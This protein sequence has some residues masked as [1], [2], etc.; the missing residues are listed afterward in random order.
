MAAAKDS[1]GLELQQAAKGILALMV[2]ERDERLNG[3]EVRRTEVILAEAG[4]SLGEIAGITG[5]KYETVKTIVRRSRNRDDGSGR[6][7]TPSSGTPTGS[8]SL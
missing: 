6:K 7:R 2:A 8:G 5:R 3:G 4:L 1:E